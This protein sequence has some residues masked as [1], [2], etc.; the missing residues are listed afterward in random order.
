MNSERRPQ[1][2]A[3]ASWSLILEI[4]GERYAIRADRPLHLAIPVDFHGPQPSAF[5]LP[6][7]RATAF[8][9]GTFV[10]DT[11]QGG[12]CNCEIVT[13][14]PHGNGTHTECVGHLTRTRESVHAA[15]CD[16]LV[17][18]T[19]VSV[20]PEATGNGGRAITASALASALQ[21][22][23]VMAGPFTRGLVVRT[24]PN[25]PGKKTRDWTGSKAPFFTA[26][27][28]RIVRDLGV[29]HL[30]CDLPSADPERDAGA[31]EA[32]RSFWELADREIAPIARHRTIT[33][34]AFVD[35]AIADGRYLLNL[36]LAPFVLD[37][38]PSRPVLF[39]VIR[40]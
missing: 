37:S 39:E 27:A 35:D 34:L 1:P 5:G 13:L 8:A 32:H 26:Q 38:A 23:G 7:A 6:R 14:A 4:Q 21:A 24:L 19:L 30:V 3:L 33:E 11:R 16:A 20:T 22:N 12:S 17:P 40:L 10:G 28:M 15:L 18:A 2:A 36:Q 25:D 31:L 9:S 29:D